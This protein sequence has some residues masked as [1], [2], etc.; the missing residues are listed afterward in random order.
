MF[1]T[2]AKILLTTAA[3]RTS[4]YEKIKKIKKILKSMQRKLDIKFI[5]KIHMDR[6][7]RCIPI[8]RISASTKSTGSAWHLKLVNN[9]TSM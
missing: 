6:L 9:L 4:C 7:Y 5:Y 3:L 8:S 1:L 2:T